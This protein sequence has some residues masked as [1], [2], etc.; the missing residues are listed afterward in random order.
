MSF[1]KRKRKLFPGM[2]DHE[3]IRWG[4]I[5]VLL[6]ATAFLCG[7]L[8]VLLA[9]LLGVSDGE[10]AV[11]I[12]PYGGG[13]QT[14]LPTV[15]TSTLPTPA[16]TD[17]PVQPTATPLPATPITASTTAGLQQ[18]VQLS[19]FSS[20]VSSATFSLDGRWL[21]AGTSDGQ[22]RV[23]VLA[24]GVEVFTFQSD[25]N[26]VG[27]VAFSP[28]STRLAAAGQD[29][30]VRRWDL[31]TGNALPA[32]EGPGAPVNSVAF[33]ANGAWLAAA[34]DDAKIY[35]WD[36]DGTLQLTLEGHSSYV[37]SVAFSAD[38]SILAS[39]SVDDTLRLWNI[40]EGTPRSILPG[41]TSNVTAV[42]FSADNNWL[43]ST[44]A[45]HLVR[46]WNLQ[47]AEALRADSLVLEGHTENINDVAF[48]PDGSLLA[49]A[50]GGIE[51]NTVRLWR[52]P[53][54][55]LLRTLTLDDPVN[56]VAF[57]PD[58]TRLATGGASFLALWG[59]TTGSA[60]IV[61]ATTPPTQAYQDEVLGEPGVL[62][63]TGCI[64]V[65]GAEET[66]VRTGPATTYS[67]AGTLAIDTSVQAVGW[68]QGTEEGFTWW[69]LTNGG[70]IRGD[71]LAN[72]NT[73]SDACWQLPLMNSADD[74]LPTAAPTIAAP[75][76]ALPTVTGAPT[77]AED[78]TITTQTEDVN[79]RNGPGITYDV[80][81]QLPLGQ[82][83]NAH[84]WAFDDEGYVWWQL[85]VGGWVRAD[86][87]SFPEFC[88]T[89]PALEP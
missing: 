74:P 84:G 46:L 25:S 61:Q 14:P 87:V 27:S 41:H 62:D 21:A 57:S 81:D 32:L 16:P 55:S 64:L 48:S 4:L 3:G 44:G 51:D 22:I 30:V 50:S 5:G 89:L 42:A 37:S 83:F 86:T 19:G 2:A 66:N 58:G 23:W 56:S 63:E 1:F 10:Q 73:L 65:T 36:Q 72:V 8:Y 26:R 67:Q 71:T 76:T 40:P 47:T 20:P 80:I 49:T 79:R 45:D 69:R 15:D 54:G 31:T 34:S 17:V 24:T 13:E 6:V 29:N 35:V 53:D 68:T 28:D 18:I 39:G 9:P 38:S 75:A 60:P 43:A 85:S 70:W 12:V 82:T 59:T 88:L 77:D 78:C 11:V 33:S 52:V 7:L